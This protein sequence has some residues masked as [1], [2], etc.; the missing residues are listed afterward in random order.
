MAP[1]VRKKSQQDRANAQ[2]VKKR[3]DERIRQH[4]VR[5][6][7][8]GNNNNNTSTGANTSPINTATPIARDLTPSPTLHGS[9]NMLEMFPPSAFIDQIDPRQSM[10]GLTGVNQA[11]PSSFT[12]DQIAQNFVNPMPGI[13]F[14]NTTTQAV[15]NDSQSLE[16]LFGQNIDGAHLYIDTQ[17]PHHDHQY[18]YQQNI[19]PHSLQQWEVDPELFTSMATISTTPSSSHPVFQVN[20][21]PATLSTTDVPQIVTQKPHKTPS[22]PDPP[23]FSNGPIL[24]R[25][26]PD[27]FQHFSKFDTDGSGAISFDELQSCLT[28]K[29]PSRRRHF[30]N[31]VI[32]ALIEMFDNSKY[33]KLL[34][35]TYTQE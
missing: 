25:A 11:V 20:N 26:S 1:L 35:C 21:Q 23:I 30:N 10:Q 9:T 17:Q 33:H 28:N 31:E 6:R 16:L 13:D 3:F 27:L 18:Q 19:H 29:A 24:V 7:V 4:I 14:S 32:L 15:P 22:R 34:M 5:F 8:N 12:P 2:N